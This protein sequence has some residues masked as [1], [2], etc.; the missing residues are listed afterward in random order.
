MLKKGGYLKQLP[1]T[2]VYKPYGSRIRGR[3]GLRSLFIYFHL[4]VTLVENGRL[5]GGYADF[6]ICGWQK[7]K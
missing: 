5:D 2:A 6:P 4:D 3:I 1:E 7:T